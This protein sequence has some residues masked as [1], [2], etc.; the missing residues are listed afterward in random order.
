VTNLIQLAIALVMDLELYRPPRSTASAAGG[1]IDE[2]SK[3]RGVHR[4]RAPHTLEES[5][6]LLGCFYVSS[7]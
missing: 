2:A 1:L 5:R 7:M 6:A 3:A 4:G